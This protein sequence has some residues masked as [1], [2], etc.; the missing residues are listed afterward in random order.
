MKAQ[1]SSIDAL[2]AI[3]LF[4]GVYVF[5]M[6]AYGNIQVTPDEFDELVVKTAFVNSRLLSSPG[7]PSNW[8]QASV[9][10]LG[11]ALN[12]V[13]IEP[14]KLASFLNLSQTNLSRTTELL[15]IQGYRFYFN[16]THL[17][18]STLSINAPSFNGSA[19]VGSDFNSTLAT[20]LRSVA[21]YNG[22]RVFVYLKVGE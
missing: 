15:G 19:V 3:L 9:L 10:Q 13:V 14:D 8:T 22:S 6:N 1:V 20:G 4:T 11:L 12:R 21:I 2:V 7:E 5:L 16:L 18:G 17:N